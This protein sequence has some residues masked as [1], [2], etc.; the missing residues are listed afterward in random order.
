MAEGWERYRL[1]IFVLVA[2][3]ILIGLGMVLDRQIDSPRTLDLRSDE[4]SASETGELKVYVT[5]AVNQPGVYSLRPGDRVIDAIAAAGG[6]VDGADL[7]RVNLAKRVRDEDQ[8]TVPRRVPE[9]AAAGQDASPVS[10]A[11]EQSLININ[12]ASAELLDTLPGIG[13]VRSQSIVASRER[14]GLF[15]RTEELVE[16][17]LIPRSVYDQI[18]DRITVGP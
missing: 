16:R 4:L 18:R 13:A 17:Q 11:S 10:T 9:V 3:P 7:E 5:G 1:L 2:V 8:I 15:L 6:P 12:T 14:D